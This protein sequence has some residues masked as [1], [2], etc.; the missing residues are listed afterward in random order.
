MLKSMV[1]VVDRS[2]FLHCVGWESEVPC[3]RRVDGSIHFYEGTPAS[4]R[5]SKVRTN[6]GATACNVG[7]KVLL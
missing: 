2:I 7:L 4:D 1:I 6:A 5:T 3:T